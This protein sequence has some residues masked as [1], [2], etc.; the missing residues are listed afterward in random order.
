MEATPRKRNIEKLLSFDAKS[1]EISEKLYPKRGGRF[2]KAK[3]DL[4]NWR[5]ESEKPGET[6]ERVLKEASVP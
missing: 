6:G 3:A 5:N 4:I 2:E 1:K